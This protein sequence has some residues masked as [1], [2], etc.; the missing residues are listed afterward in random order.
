[1]S[2]SL[3]AASQNHSMSASARF[4]SS[5]NVAMSWRSMNRFSRLFATTSSLGFQITSPMTTG[6]IASD[7]RF[8]RL[9]HSAWMEPLPADFAKQL[10]QVIEPGGEGAAAEVIGAAVHLDDARLG[11]FLELLADRV[12]SSAKPITEPE[13][14]DLLKKSTKYGRPAA[15]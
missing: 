1:M 15:S 14:R 4:S 5:A 2:M 3:I 6:C 12:R 9:L 10:L 13:L 7:S 11:I 8:S